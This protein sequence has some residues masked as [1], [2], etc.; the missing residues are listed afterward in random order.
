MGLKE[1][2]TVIIFIAIA[3]PLAFRVTSTIP[4]F[5]D[6]AILG[7]T[8]LFY[9]IDAFMNRSG[10]GSY[11][12]SAL[13]DAVSTTALLKAVPRS[14]TPAKS[15]HTPRSASSLNFRKR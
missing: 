13:I 5:A 10:P 14:T 11:A 2:I 6:D 7:I 9:A 8:I 4:G 1:G 3:A 15:Q 12:P